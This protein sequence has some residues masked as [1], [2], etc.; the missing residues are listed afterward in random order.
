MQHR[1]G[2][3]HEQNFNNNKWFCLEMRKLVL[4]CNCFAW[5]DTL[6]C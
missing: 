4:T 6:V 1:R 5:E 2:L 3:G